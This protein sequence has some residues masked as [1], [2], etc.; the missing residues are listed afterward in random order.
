MQ[1]VINTEGKV[2]DAKVLDVQASDFVE[3]ALFAIKQWE[4]EPAT[5]EGEPVAVYYNVLVNFGATE[6]P[7][8]PAERRR[9]RSQR[10]R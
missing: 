6:K 4:F 1:A 8:G 3:A 9:K 10:I 2:E 5:L 7:D